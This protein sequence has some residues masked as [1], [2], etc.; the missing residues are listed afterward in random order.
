MDTL[1]ETLT[2]AAIY[3]VF[4]ASAMAGMKAIDWLVPDPPREPI[5]LQLKD[6]ATTVEPP[7]LKQKRPYVIG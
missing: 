7:V 4:G 1:K 2:C 5:Q 6:T 3:A